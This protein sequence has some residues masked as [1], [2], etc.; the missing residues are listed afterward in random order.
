MEPKGVEP[1]DTVKETLLFIDEN[2]IGNSMAVKWQCIC[3][4]D[5]RLLFVADRWNDLPEHL[6]ETIALL[7]AKTPSNEEAPPNGSDPLSKM[8]FDIT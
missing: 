6:K 4:S 5:S 1:C 8:I 3:G 2:D 7:V